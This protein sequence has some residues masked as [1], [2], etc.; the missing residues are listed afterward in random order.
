LDERAMALAGE[1]ANIGVNRVCRI[2]QMQRPPLTWQHDG[3]P[4]LA[5]LVRW[6]DLG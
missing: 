3:R 1:L 5:D 6:T 2:G 4:N